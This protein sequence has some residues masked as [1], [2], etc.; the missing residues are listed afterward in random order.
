MNINF[1]SK[2]FLEIIKVYS[3]FKV[4]SFKV[5]K[6][7][8]KKNIEDYS[9]LFLGKI[10]DEQRNLISSFDHILVITEEPNKLSNNFIIVKNNTSINLVQ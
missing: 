9:V 8:T 2:N 3:I 10:S 4:D 7:S 1:F 5:K 6:L